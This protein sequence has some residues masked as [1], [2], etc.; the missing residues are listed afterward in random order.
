MITNHIMV[1]RHWPC[2]RCMPPTHVI[3]RWNPR[4]HI[5]FS[6]HKGLDISTK[7]VDSHISWQMAGRKMHNI[8]LHSCI[9]LA[10]DDMHWWCMHPLESQTKVGK[11]EDDHTWHTT[12]EF[13]DVGLQLRFRCESNQVVRDDNDTTGKNKRPIASSNIKTKKGGSWWEPSTAS[14]VLAHT[15]YLFKTLRSP[16]NCIK[17]TQL[18]SPLMLHLRD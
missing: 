11:L 4:Q 7:P 8:D 14:T 12:K 17:I 5:Y 9:S 2:P 10:T 3:A 6:I 18:A 16:T 15:S 1:T 13:S